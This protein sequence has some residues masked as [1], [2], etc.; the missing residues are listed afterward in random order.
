MIPTRRAAAQSQTPLQMVRRDMENERNEKRRRVEE[1][2]LLRSLG[3]ENEDLRRKIQKQAVERERDKEQRKH[4][5]KKEKIHVDKRKDFIEFVN[6]ESE[7]H[8]EEG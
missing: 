3:N 4:L 5:T 8:N 2:K 7:N 1:T 6:T